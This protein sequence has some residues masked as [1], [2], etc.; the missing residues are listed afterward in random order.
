MYDSDKQQ[1]VQLTLTIVML[2]VQLRAYL[3]QMV[4]SLHPFPVNTI[5]MCSLIINWDHMVDSG[6]GEHLTTL[7]IYTINI[8]FK[9][10]IFQYFKYL[11][12]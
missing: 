11:I 8:S 10:K 3:S 1:S 7:S 5:R 9:K 12:T 6:D 4:F 2:M